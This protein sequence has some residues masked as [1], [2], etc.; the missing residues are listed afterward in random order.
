M[1][2][3]PARENIF[4]PEF[5]VLEITRPPPPGKKK[6]KILWLCLW[7]FAWILE[8][9]G[10]AIYDLDFDLQTRPFFGCCCFCFFGGIGSLNY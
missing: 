9:F 1:L 6:K 7:K 10:G 8:G 3:L 5:I 2:C 4:W